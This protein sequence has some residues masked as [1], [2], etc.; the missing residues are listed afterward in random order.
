MSQFGT[1]GFHPPDS[2]H[3]DNSVMTDSKG[4]QVRLPYI[5]LPRNPEIQK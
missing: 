2:L 1:E 5:K 3:V 4:R